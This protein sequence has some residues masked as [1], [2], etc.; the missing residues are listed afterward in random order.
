VLFTSAGI[1]VPYHIIW[2]SFS[3]GV[4]TLARYYDLMVLLISN[5]NTRIKKIW[6][7]TFI[8]RILRYP[9]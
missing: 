4:V 2:S 5:T 1:N 9:G 6:K 8:L 7:G 3:K